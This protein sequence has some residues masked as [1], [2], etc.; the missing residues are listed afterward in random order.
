MNQILSVVFLLLLLSC[1]HKAQPTST[2][3]E[4]VPAL[5]PEKPLPSW[6]GLGFTPIYLMGRFNPA[7]D[8]NFVKIP[9][10]YAN[11]G[12]RY[13]RAEV[14]EAFIKMHDAARA[15]GIQLT[16]VSATR[17]F[18]AQKSI[19]EAKW[20]GRRLVEGANIARTIPDPAQRALKI[21]EYSSMPGT[22]RH[23][24]GTDIDI[25]SL[26]SSYFKKSPGKEVYEWLSENA[27]EFGFCQPYSPKL[28][29]H[30][31]GYNEEEWH[32]S[33]L[34]LAKPLTDYAREILR[35]TMITGF[36]GS[37]TAPLIGVVKNY[38]LGINPTCLE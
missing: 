8:S 9:A 14:L 1:E 19:W 16:I 20:E 30:R 29:D 23:H 37:E 12:N 38:V 21:L 3:H 27:A 32:W 25:N 26:N 15:D 33:Y 6:E 28:P 35:D 7:A 31:T 13:L 4:S 11:S 24:W 18:S 2:D 17:N 34:P 10:Q 5:P 22:S 36:K